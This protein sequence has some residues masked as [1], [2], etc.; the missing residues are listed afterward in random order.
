[1]LKKKRIR[2]MLCFLFVTTASFCQFID[3]SFFGIEF[4]S[5]LATVR[6]KLDSLNVEFI[7]NEKHT[8]FVNNVLYSG[9][10]YDFISINFSNDK[11]NEI[12]FMTS[13]LPGLSTEERY[14][15]MIYMLQS[16]YGE[17]T[18]KKSHIIGYIDNE[19]ICTYG[20]FLNEAEVCYDDMLKFKHFDVLHIPD[21]AIELQLTR[22]Y[23]D[24][25]PCLLSTENPD[26]SIGLK[27]MS[28]GYKGIREEFKKT[29]ETYPIKGHALDYN[30]WII[31]KDWTSI[32]YLIDNI[33]VISD[34]T[35]IANIT[36]QNQSSSKTATLILL[37]YIDR[38][39]VDD[40]IIDGTSE[41]K[42]MSEF[43]NQY[44]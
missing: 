43:I 7:Q 33:S 36:I 29:E 2:L 1:M 14:A 41:K 44:K 30:H 5:S 18:F 24:V 25:I 4:G 9:Y 34:T 10:K 19:N 12:R 23:S 40:F 42:T 32:G 13:L 11:F 39:F 38:W 6:A 15:N 22:I 28:N 26:D 16:A 20:H 37:K 31:M 8:L 21:E 27:Y 35:A 17:P 3:K